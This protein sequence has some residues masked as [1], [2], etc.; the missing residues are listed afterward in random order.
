MDIDCEEGSMRNDKTGECDEI[1][2]NPRTG[3]SLVPH[4]RLKN[5]VIDE[6]LMDADL[7]NGKI[8]SHKT[9]E[10]IGFYKKTSTGRLNKIVE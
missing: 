7:K 6:N 5:H 3:R 4:S 2:I 9:G 8:Y 10:Y 1:I